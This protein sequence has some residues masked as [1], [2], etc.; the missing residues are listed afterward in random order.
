MR[1]FFADTMKLMMEGSGR[2][3]VAR[4]WRHW[5]PRQFVCF[6]CWSPAAPAWGGR[7]GVGRR[8]RGAA[9]F[10]LVSLQL[11]TV[12]FTAQTRV[13]RV[14]SSVRAGERRTRDEVGPSAVTAVVVEERKNGR[15]G[16]RRRF[17]QGV[18]DHERQGNARVE[19][20]RA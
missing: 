16:E 13:L 3:E 10:A 8:D 7:F 20:S 6:V 15:S 9:S 18:R 4:V 2:C 17:D 1:Q 5:S 12:L 14:A 19:H 11:V